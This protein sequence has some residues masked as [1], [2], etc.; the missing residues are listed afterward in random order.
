MNNLLYAELIGLRE[1]LEKRI[2]VLEKRRSEFPS[3]DYFKTAAEFKDLL[4]E[5]TGD[6]RTSKEFMAKL[7]A[8]S[9]RAK[10]A[11]IKMERS[12]DTKT[13]NREMEEEVQLN[14]A[15]SQLNTIIYHEEVRR[16]SNH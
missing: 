15:L 12:F 9:D 8:L 11:K 2:V 1:H 4:D 5:Y 13:T 16:K 10:K 14:Q 3:D 6:Q 7:V